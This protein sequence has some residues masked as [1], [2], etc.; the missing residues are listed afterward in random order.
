MAAKAAYEL[1]EAREM[2]TL[3]KTAMNELVTGQAKSYRIGTRE[4]TAFDIDE[5]LR[6]IRYYS[7]LVD[8]LQGSARSNSVARVVFRDL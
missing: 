8:S 3:C 4:Y 6:L 1:Q 7:D 5:L 2:L